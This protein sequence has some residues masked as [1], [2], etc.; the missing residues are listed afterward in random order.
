[1]RDLAGNL[2]ADRVTVTTGQEAA[3]PSKGPAYAILHYNRPDGDYGDHTS[4]DFNDYWGLHLWGDIQE[5][6]DWTAP[7]PF[8]GEDEYGRFA[9]VQ[10][11]PG[12]TMWDLSCIEVT[13]KDG[14]TEDR[15]FNPS[16]TPEIWLKADDATT[17]TS[18]AAAQGYV[19]M[20]Y[21]RDD[22]DYTDWGLH[23]WG[24]A[25]DPAEETDWTNP[26]PPTGEDDFG[27][28]WNINIVDPTQAVNFIIHRGDEKDP[29]PDQSFIPQEDATVWIMSG[30]ETI[31]KQKGA[32]LG[33]ATLHYHR[34]AGDYGD[35]T[36]ADYNDFW[37]LHTWEGADDP[38]W[39]T[40]RKPDRF[41]TFGAVFEVP[42]FEGAVQMGYIFHRGDEKDPG[43]DQFLVFAEDGY[44]V[45]QLQGADPRTRTFC[46]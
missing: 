18:Q 20:H 3:P 39:T 40:P 5:M 11:E 4:G 33:I 8:L 21:H 38:G 25:I 29:G 24:Q 31:Y 27:L 17:Y 45:W 34:P 41:D 32:A 1:V 6:I 46:R 35:Y 30:D 7:K 2:N 16:I 22:G 42:L 26:K 37:G 15:F 23:L 14:T 36:S 9:W 12:A 19:T 13:L 43:P 44:E 10:L 28:Y